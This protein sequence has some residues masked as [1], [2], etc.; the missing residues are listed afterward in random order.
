[1][2]AAGF[3]VP[4]VVIFDLDG[5]LLDS[6]P[7]IEHS[8]RAA[9]ASCG[10]E[11]GHADLRGLIGPP[12]RAIF[13]TLSPKATQDELDRLVRAFRASYDVEGIPRTPA[14]TD[15]VDVLLELKARRRKLFVASN[16]PRQISMAILEQVGLA[17][18]FDEI[19]TR[20]SR[21]PAYTGKT[22]MISYLTDK[23][24]LDAPDCLLVG[25]TLEDAE[26]ARNSGINFC[27]MTHGYGDVPAGS[28]IPVALRLDSFA[29][30]LSILHQ[31]PAQP[32]HRSAL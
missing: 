23:W 11:M 3:R 25:D 26:A 28:D 4:G 9:F 16:K 21:L 29:A 31:E 24:K 27:L 2:A 1:M 6:L 22:E 18:V 20:D 30:M 13:A 12:I 19:V 8:V 7:G 15:T 17:D 10:L 5:T 32:S 14:F